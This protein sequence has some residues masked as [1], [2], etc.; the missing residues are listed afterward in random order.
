MNKNMTKTEYE[1]LRSVKS[2]LGDK[3]TLKN[4]L[5]FVMIAIIVAWLPDGIAGVLNVSTAQYPYAL[6]LVQIGVPLLLVVVLIYEFQSKY[7]HLE[8]NVY[9]YRIDK[10]PERFLIIFL[11]DLRD[12]MLQTTETSEDFTTLFL[13]ESRHSW[14][15]PYRAIQYHQSKLEALYVIPSPESLGQYRLFEKLVKK[16]FPELALHCMH[17]VDFE[18]IKPV[19]AEVNR[20][21]EQIKKVC[22]ENSINIREKEIVLDVTGGQKV[23]SIVGAISS[24]RYERRF[25]YV[26]TNTKEVRMYDIEYRFE[27]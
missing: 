24:L 20:T 9:P 8:A 17:A 26:S 3:L 10:T 7:K 22:K 23:T 16:E 18:E 4:V 2:F 12:K 27:E 19:F 15:M 1:K 6:P 14:E 5:F 13:A 11:S 25:E 21:Y